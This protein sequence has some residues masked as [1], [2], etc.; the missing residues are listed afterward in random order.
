MGVD[1]KM[2]RCLEDS[3]QHNI[4]MMSQQWL[5]GFSHVYVGAEANFWFLIFFRMICNVLLEERVGR[6]PEQEAE[7]TV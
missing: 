2:Y 3:A 6:S 1:S 5:F 7:K 4:A